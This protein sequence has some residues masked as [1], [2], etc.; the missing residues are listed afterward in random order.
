MINESETF[1]V[2]VT[3]TNNIALPGATVIFNTE[4]GQTNSG[5]KVTFTAPSVNYDTFYTLEVHMIG[6]LPASASMSVINVVGSNTEPNRLVMSAPPSLHENE[7]FS[8]VVRNEQ[9]FPSQMS[10]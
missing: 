7:Q 3:D 2:T 4:Q 8:V 1:S 9:G 6:Y 5:G 10:R